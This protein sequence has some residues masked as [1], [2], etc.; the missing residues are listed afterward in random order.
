M[1]T[2]LHKYKIVIFIPIMVFL[3]ISMK[4]EAM[5]NNESLLYSTKSKKE[6]INWAK[7]K[8]GPTKN[9]PLKVYD[10]EVF[11]VLG[12]TAF[13]INRLAIHVYVYSL[14]SKQWDLLLL[15]FT[16]SSDIKVKVDKDN[17]L[18]FSKSGSLL[19]I[20]PIDTLTLDFQNNE[21]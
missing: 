9:I 15:R 7:N 13:G 14:T 5:S 6:I 18:F 1:K 12:D 4:G 3:F 20:Q 16:N 17:I 21:Q 2:I 8:Y 19:F 10:K 11:I